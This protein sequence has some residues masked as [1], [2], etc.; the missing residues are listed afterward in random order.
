M[1]NISKTLITAMNG[2]KTFG[3]VSSGISNRFLFYYNIIII[4][5]MCKKF[6][7]FLNAK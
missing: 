2:F 4:W 7:G 3:I 5:S 6:Y 1:K